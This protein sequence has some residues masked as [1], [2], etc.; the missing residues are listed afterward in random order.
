MI[1][2]LSFPQKMFFFK[3]MSQVYIIFIDLDR[4]VPD[5]PWDERYIYLHENH[6]FKPNVGLDIPSPMERMGVKL[7]L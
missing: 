2:I 7:D 1:W 3:A 6:Q 5:A 4:N